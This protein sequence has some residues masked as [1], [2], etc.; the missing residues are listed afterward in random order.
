MSYSLRTEKMW[1]ETRSDLA[2]MFATWKVR[3]WSISCPTKRYDAEVH[4]EDRG[5]TIQYEHP[6][7]GSRELT[8]DKQPRPMDNLRALYLALD[9]MRL[10][11][12]RGIDDVVREAY[13]QLA[14]PVLSLIHI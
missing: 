3:S 6:V 4:R 1:S 12:L 7:H 10:N 2:R 8:Y 11:E 5:V 13:L 14:A 9:S